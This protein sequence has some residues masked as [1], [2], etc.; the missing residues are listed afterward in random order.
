MYDNLETS[1]PHGTR[2]QICI[3]FAYKILILI[4]NF[5]ELFEN[6][7]AFPIGPIAINA[8]PLTSIM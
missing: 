5:S 6:G 4:L 3:I 2:F 8:F 7:V 1:I